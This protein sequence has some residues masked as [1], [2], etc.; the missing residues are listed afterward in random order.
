MDD[1]FRCDLRIVS[2]AN[3]FFIETIL[4]HFGIRECFNEI[5]TNP[6]FVDKE[7]RLR[8]SPH[9]DFPHG[10][11]LCPPNMCKVHLLYFSLNSALFICREIPAVLNHRVVVTGT[12][13]R[14]DPTPSK[15]EKNDLPWRR[16][17]RL[18]PK[19]KATS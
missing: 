14:E 15:N 7:G 18:L 4:E 6:N 17:W 19:F 8:I 1:R 3:Y 12:D 9:H 2:D 5:N 10:C 13:H 16:G 11:K